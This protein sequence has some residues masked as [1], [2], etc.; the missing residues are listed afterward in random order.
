MALADALQRASPP[1]AKLCSTYE[2]V[3]QLRVAGLALDLAEP[4][5][6]VLHERDA[7]G[8]HVARSSSAT[9]SRGSRRTRSGSVLM[10]RPI[11]VLDVGQ[12]RRPAGDGGAEH[13]VVAAG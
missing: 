7:L 9:G 6:V 3:E 5:V 13:D 11:I 12:L 8:L 2:R 10:N 1:P 4:E